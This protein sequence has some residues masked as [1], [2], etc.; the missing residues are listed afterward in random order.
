MLARLICLAAFVLMISQACN[1]VEVARWDFEET[2]GTTATDNSGQ[3]VGTLQGSASLDVDGKFGS[4]IQIGGA[5]GGLIIDAAD[6]GAFRL[7]G[8]FSIALWV[9]SDVAIGNYTRFVDI[10]AADGGLT[11]SYRLMTGNNADEDNFRFMS[12]QNGSNT[13]NIHTRDLAVGTWLLLVVRHDLDGDVTLNVLQDG[14]NVNA[15]FVASNSESWPTAGPIVY[16]EGD[17]K[18]G[19]QNNGNNP[20]E[21]QMD[22]IAFYDE[23]LTDDQI[24][25]M[26]Y[27]AGSSEYPLATGPD[28]ADGAVLEAT[29]ANLGWR[30]G[31]FA[32][33]HDLYF[34]TGFDDVNDGVEGAF[35]GNLGTTSQIVGFPSFPAPDGLQPGTTY[36]WRI[37]EVNDTE[38]NSPWKGPVWSFSIPPKNA[39]NLDPVDGAKY[40]DPDVTLG[41]TPGLNSAL[42]HMYFGDNFDDVN[43]G[44]GTTYKG[45]LTE[46][47]YVPGTLEMDKAYY[48]RVDEFDGAATHKGDVVSFTTM[49]VIDVADPTLIGWW[50]FDAGLGTVAP[51]WSGHGNHGMLVNPNW[52]SPG[53]IGQSA[54]E[55]GSNSYMAIRN[56]VPDANQTEVSVSAW[57]R[58]TSSGMQ[59][60]ASFDRSDYWRFEV[61]SQYTEPGKV[62]WEVSTDTGVVDLPSE[63]RIDDGQW[64]HVAGVFDNGTMT[65]YIDGT[66]DAS[67]VGGNTFG[68][69]ST[70]YGFVGSQSEATAFDGDRSG[71]PGYWLGSMD[72]VR[73]YD[74]ALTQDDIAQVMRG[75]LLLA[76][77][78]QPPSGIYDIEDVPPSLTWSPGDMAAQHDVYFGTD[79]QAVQNADAA[80]TTGVY[81]GQQTGTT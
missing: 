71:S 29:W 61:G 10:A 23:V 47:T 38:P 21:G 77:G 36:Y 11:D 79:E 80:D 76:W 69:A 27:T 48:W 1:A 43:D 3:Y 78:H 65:I 32:V 30:A 13:S 40:I 31:D 63:K 17:L 28:P 49:P 53:W 60:I 46:P 67:T 58:T 7:E 5:N 18:F 24:A 56:L 70:R 4:G 22:G 42:H 12:R 72:D 2:S 25:A 54:M 81:R 57:V 55:F 14:D 20:V 59:T 41:W 9:K 51:D 62:G 66:P 44:A 33:S 37:D 8:D 19:R 6:S 64:H 52:L 73:I 15:A 75:D 39:Y 68:T 35:A 26:F 74:R 34:G 16:A 50:K 45:G